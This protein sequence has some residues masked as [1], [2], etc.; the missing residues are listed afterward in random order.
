MQSTLLIFKTE[1][2]IYQSKAYLDNK[3]L[4]GKISHLEDPPEIRKMSVRGLYGNQEFHFLF[5]SMIY[6]LL[7]LKFISKTENYIELKVR[8]QFQ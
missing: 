8:C 5:W 3:I 4:F 1:I 6:L 7:K 2:L